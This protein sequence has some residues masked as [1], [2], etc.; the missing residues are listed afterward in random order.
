MEP[1]PPQHIETPLDI[2][3]HEGEPKSKVWMRRAL[4]AV[5]VILCVSFAAP[6]FGS[7]SGAL[8]RGGHKLWGTYTVRGQKREV[9][10]DDFR[11]MHAALAAAMRMLASPDAHV[12]DDQVW[13]T[14]LLDAAAR[15]EGVHVSDDHIARFIAEQPAFQRD[16][17][18]D[19]DAYRAQIAQLHRVTGVDHEGLTAAIRVLLRSDAYR[20]LYGAAF[21]IPESREAYEDWKKQ[22]VKLTVDWVAQPFAPLRSKAADAPVTDDDLRR[23]AGLP[24]VLAM[25]TIPGRRGVEAAYVR[26]T[27]LTAEHRRAL[28]EFAVAN[29]LLGGDTVE[30][31]SWKWFWANHQPGTGFFNRET[32]A[33]LRRPEYDASVKAW[34]ATPEPRGEKPKAPDADYPEAP[35]DQ[36]EKVWFD[37]VSKEVLSREVL[38][39][40][41]ARAERESKSLA[42]ILPDYEKFGIRLAVPER[43]L[44][45]S[46]IESKFP[47]G[48]GRDSELEQA[49]RTRFRAPAPTEAFTPA[50][51]VEPVPAMRVTNRVRERGWIVARWSSWEPPKEMS[52]PTADEVA[53]A[54]APRDKVELRERAAEF[55]RVY[56]ANE[57]GR[58]VLDGIRKAAESAGPDVEARRAALRKAAEAAGLTVRTVKRFNAKTERVQPPLAAADATQAQRDAAQAV[59]FRNRVQEDYAMLSRQSVGWL[60]DPILVDDSLGAAFLSLVVEKHEPEP[61]EMDA[62]TLR[63]ERFMRQQKDRGIVRD[64]LSTKELKRRFQLELTEEGRKATEREPEP[65]TPTR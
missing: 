54:D 47:L 27:E 59:T 41:A 13:S 30:V 5:V 52:L 56:R 28:E 16:G 19:A 32:W 46:E 55:F 29:S 42:A 34:E 4:L 36:F 10:E 31:A 58:E 11:R 45:D 21:S 62:G 50:V 1:R 57:L 63:M 38:R 48:L 64:A 49:I 25:R 22:N 43:P 33:E 6:T 40:M 20:S 7:C 8:G 18:F 53:A 2:E 26:I 44:N 60:R 14:I 51:L 24:P 15:S 35:A 23:V 39:H 9:Y 61:I 17:R 65:E 37:H 12:D 3:P